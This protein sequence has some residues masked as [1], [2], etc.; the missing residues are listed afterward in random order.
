M[1]SAH[2]YL[3][4]FTDTAWSI[5]LESGP[6]VILSLLVGGLVHEFV[7]TSR[8]RHSL[9][10]RGM[11]GMGGAV[12][13][14]A[15]LPIC[16]CGVI[17]LAVSMYRSGIRTGTVMAF[18][19]ATPIINPAAVILSLALLGPR[20]TIAYISL[21]LVLPVLLGIMTERWG[22][23]PPEPSHSDVPEGASMASDL[24]AAPLVTR[25]L[26]GL[27]WGVFD[28]G[29]SIGFYLLIGIIL[30][31]LLMTFVP[32]N[33]MHQFLGG[34]SLLG[35]AVVAVLGAAIYV[36]AVANIPLAAALIAAGAGP[37]ASIVFLVTGTATN[38]P[39]LL[40]LYHTIGRRTVIIYTLS[41]VVASFVA[42]ILVNAWLLPGFVPQVDPLRSLDLLSSG[43]RLQLSLTAVLATVSVYAMILLGGVGTWQRVRQRFFARAD[44][45]SC[46]SSSS[47]C[48]E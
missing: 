10:R 44:A 31:A 33:W 9:N 41:L 35:L 48:G 17:P 1:T 19:A 13:L 45:S 42:G 36:C 15:L 6:W 5:S 43:S 40:A 20:I 22:D 7:T 29:P 2:H 39:E 21:G 23:R 18:A 16:S 12:A 37:G 27:R 47:C 14:G 24:Q 25:V 8:L 38:L 26:R 32:Q 46:C 28:L 34:N 11:T 30:A 3:T 4:I